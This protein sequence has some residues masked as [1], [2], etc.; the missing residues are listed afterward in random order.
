M[1]D[2][3]Q[4]SFGAL[5]FRGDD[6]W[7]SRGHWVFM[8]FINDVLKDYLHKG[9]VVYIDDVLFYSDNMD[10]HID[11]LRNILKTL[12]DNSLFFK[13]NKCEF[14]KSEFTFLG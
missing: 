3:I 5:F 10:D 13:L 9:A 6:F 14:H 1:E 12:A 2:F 7:A 8:N 4:Q 11:L